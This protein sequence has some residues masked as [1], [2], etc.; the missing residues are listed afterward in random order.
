MKK[1]TYLLMALGMLFSSITFAQLYT[2]PGCTVTLGTNT[3]GPMYSVAGANATSR[4]AVI[5][6]ASQLTGIAGQTLTSIYFNRSTAS[7]AMA[8]GGSYKIYLKETS[9]TDFGSGSV[10][11]ATDIST[12]TLVYNSDPSSVAGTTAGW[13]NF[14]LS[15]NFIYSGTQNLAFYMEYSNPTA[16]TAITWIYDYT[17]P[18]VDTANNN[19]TKYD[20]NTTGTQS[21]TLASSNYRRPYVAFDFLVSCN[22]PNTLSTSAVTTTTATASWVENA[23]QP[24][25]GYEYYYSTSN[26]PPSPT[27]TPN[28]STATGVSTVNLT[29]LTSGTTYYLW[30]RGNCGSSDKSIWSGPKVFTTLCSQVTAFVQNFD[31]SPTGTGNLPNCWAKAG[32]SANVYNTTGSVAP[33]SP[34]NRLY[35]NISATTTAFAI[36]PP[37]SNLQA[38]THRLKFKG[39]ATSASKKARVGYFTTPL[40]ATTFVMLQEFDLPSTAATTALEFVVNPTGVPAG[41]TNLVLNLV[42]GVAAT[43]YFDDFKWEMLPACP[44]TTGLVVGAI[45]SSGA[46]A[47]WDAITGVT[48]YEYAVTTSATPPTSGT[49]TT[50]TFAIV[51]GLSPQTVYYLHVRSTCSGGTFGIWSTSASFTTACAPIT[52]LPWNEGFEGITTV[53][54]TAFPPCWLKENG[55]YSSAIV[56]TYNTPNTGTKYLRD[57]WSATNE[58]MWTPGFNLTAGTSYDFSSYIQGDGFTGWTVDYFVNNAQNSVG[59]T[60]V[61]SQYAVPGSGTIAIQSYSY[62]P[63]TFIPTTSGVYYFAVRVNQTSATPWYIAFD[64]F[65]LKLSPAC[66]VQTGLIVGGITSTGANTSWDAMT[67]ATGYEYAVTTSSTP[68]TSGTATTN[69]FAIISGLNPQTLYYLHVRAT[70]TGGTFGNWASPLSFTT[71]CGNVT[72]FTQNF[73]G[74]TASTL[75]SGMPTCW[76]K[77]GSLGSCYTSTTTPVG[78]APNVIYMFGSSTAQATMRMQ[79]VSNL[80]AGTNRIKFKMRSSSTTVFPNLDFGYLTDP[81]DATTFVSLKNFVT[82][83]NTFVTYT[84]SPPAGTYSDY[85][86]VKMNGAVYGTIY[87]DDFAWE[88]NPACPDQTG[89]VIG[90]ATTTGATFSWD[91]ITGVAGYEYAVTTS[92]TPPASGT[93]TTNTFAT[94][95]S[96]TPQTQYY[97]HVRAMCSVGVYGNWAS[98]SFITGYCIPS[99]TNSTT[100]VNDFSTTGGSANISNLATGYSS[101]GYNNASTQ[102]VQ[103]FAT[104]SFTFNAAIIGGTAGFSIWVDWNNDLVFDNATEKVFNTTSYSNGPFTGTITIPAGT[105]LGNHRMRIT[106]DYLAPNPSLPC[107]NPTTAEFEDYTISVIAPPTCGAP[108]PVASIIGATT[109]TLS[110][111]AVA[112]AAVGYEYVLDNLATNPATAGTATTALSYAASSLT[113]NTTYYFHIRSVCSAGTFSAWSTVSFTTACAAQNVPYSENFESATIPNLPN[114]TSQQNVGTGNLWATAASPGYG[115]TTNALRYTY[116]SANPANVWFY[117]NGVN[118]TAATNYKISFDYGSTGT[119]FPEKLKVAYGTSAAASSMTNVLADYTSV[120]NPLPINSVI[121]FTAPTTGV[122]YFGFNANSLA[123]EFYLFVDNILVDVALANNSFTNNSLSVYPNP[124]KDILNINYTE[125]ITKIQVVNMLGQEVISK[126]VNNTQNQIDMSHLVQGTYL[127]KITSNDLVKTMKVI[128]Q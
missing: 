34:S 60:Q 2:V 46:S 29:G 118:L 4:T 93:A 113:A 3:Y 66:P 105:T 72:N 32:T 103:G 5:Y 44:D 54:T 40:D 110:W 47:S 9:N 122:Y 100:Y 11:W 41:I 24:Q 123:D 10:T 22:A 84:Y 99:S 1:I 38:G 90:T 107:G 81:N 28:G 17:L 45:T 30:V 73:D 18:C 114:C 120:V 94:V 20:N 51:S 102:F 89:V 36:L 117:T 49:A 26:T 50:N 121:N 70:C 98:T 15:T 56:S 14:P 127:V 106:T 48:G 79:P 19:T 58:Y 59:A 86:A 43:A 104:S 21:A 6:N 13:K 55:D 115:F 61:G 23:V 52:A 8:P 101:G 96:L 71:A 42:D 92:A 37:V 57:A 111:P 69:T 76:A 33:M 65:E 87:L 64:D 97:A 85:P 82:T 67:G 7:G 83:G 63:R 126:S 68:P 112:S 75:P 95:S 91:A 62:V 16:S 53:G 125:N 31:T 88:A 119:T 77:V 25:N 74:V 109:A 108:A 39:Y 80:G 27:A 128:K 12:A 35:M 124:V 116:N 78:S